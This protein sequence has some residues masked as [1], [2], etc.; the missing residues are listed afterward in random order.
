MIQKFRVSKIYIYMLINMFI[1][2]AH[3]K[4]IKGYSKH[5]YNAIKDL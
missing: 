3:I 2:Q 1:Q 5:I 4:L